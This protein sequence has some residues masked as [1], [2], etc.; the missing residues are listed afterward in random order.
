M[1]TEFP[2]G[3]SDRYPRGCGTRIDAAVP[4][5]LLSLIVA[6]EVDEREV[7][8]SRVDQLSQKHREKR[9]SFKIA[10]DPCSISLAVILRNVGA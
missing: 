2:T 8:A 7:L 4:P 6:G 5:L 1:A 3:L 9:P 10:V